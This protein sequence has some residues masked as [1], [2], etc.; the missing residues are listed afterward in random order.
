MLNNLL[1]QRTAYWCPCQTE[2]QPTVCSCP[3]LF[4]VFFLDNP[5][6]ICCWNASSKGTI[7]RTEAKMPQR[8]QKMHSKKKLRFVFARLKTIN[9]AL[10]ISCLCS[11]YMQEHAKKLRSF[12]VPGL[13]PS[14]SPTIIE[15]PSS[16]TYCPMSGKPLRCVLSPLFLIVGLC[17]HYLS[18]L[19]KKTHTQFEGISACRIY[20]S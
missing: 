12:W 9:Y 19:E 1:K 11:Y 14:A 4:S 10:L 16:K 13:T 15:K 18:S 17:A 8:R 2:S 7:R 3:L 5:S 6:S 20:A